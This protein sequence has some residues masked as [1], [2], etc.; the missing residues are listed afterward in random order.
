M[1]RA[2]FLDR[3]GV[4]NLDKSYVHLREDFVFYDDIFEVCRTA[5]ERDFL[6]FVVTNQAGIGRGYYTETQFNELTS[7]MIETFREKGVHITEVYH[8]PF[9]PS[10]ALGAYKRESFDRKPNPGMILKAKDQH[11]IDLLSSI[12]VGDKATDIQAGLSA[13]VG[14]NLLLDPKGN[15]S[16]PFHQT[17]F[18]INSL[19]E[20]KDFLR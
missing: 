5:A 17:V 10:E 19:Q 12:L 13:G 15:E 1:R 7:W 4:I 8:C 14:K 18:R 11:Q 3:D 16:Q 2:L 20:V 9:H 6:I